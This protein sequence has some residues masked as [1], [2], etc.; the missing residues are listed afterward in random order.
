MIK[1]LL[2]EHAATRA[3]TAAARARRDAQRQS[4]EQRQLATAI[5]VVKEQWGPGFDR[6]GQN[7]QRTLVKA[8]VLSII[9]HM[10]SVED[11]PAGRLAGAAMIWLP[12]E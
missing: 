6:L 5:A 9:S 1:R 7:L 11:T 3:A 4:F 2:P 12:A 10:E 8:Q